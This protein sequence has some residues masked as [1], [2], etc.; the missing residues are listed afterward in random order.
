MKYNEPIFKYFKLNDVINRKHSK[1]LIQK[2]KYLQSKYYSIEHHRL[3]TC[4]EKI[5]RALIKLN[6]HKILPTCKS[7]HTHKDTLIHIMATLK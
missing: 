6:L 4:H 5:I 7:S 2:F 1:L 3:T